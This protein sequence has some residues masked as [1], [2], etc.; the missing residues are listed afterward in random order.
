MLKPAIIAGALLCAL[1]AS[2]AA[3]ETC[4]ASWYQR[5]HTTANGER[6]DPD[7]L[8]VAMRSYDFGGRYRI[9]NLA[10][11]RS[12][13]VRHNDYGPAKWTGKC[14]DLS[15]GAAREIGMIRAGVVRVRVEVVR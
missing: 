15:R 2:A 6:F 14:I 5:G 1:T 10:N 13:V 8:T 7:G 12:V 11:G 9:T 3:A 4:K